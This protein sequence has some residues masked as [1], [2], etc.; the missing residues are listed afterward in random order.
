MPLEHSS[1]HYCCFSMC[2]LETACFGSCLS[3]VFWKLFW[4]EET[5][6]CVLGLLGVKRHTVM[7]HCPSSSRWSCQ[8]LQ[9]GLEHLNM[10]LEEQR[11]QQELQE[12]HCSCGFIFWLCFHDWKDFFLQELDVELDVLENLERLVLAWASNIFLN[13]NH[14]YTFL[15]PSRP[16][17]DGVSTA[18]TVP[19]LISEVVVIIEY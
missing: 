14:W 10:D 1:L 17:D 13:T 2:Y 6:L 11:L 9:D 4:F 8:T 18:E 3:M 12:L 19:A 5:L 7:S 15:V 16:K